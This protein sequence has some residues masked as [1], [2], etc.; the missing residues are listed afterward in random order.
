ML[1]TFSFV[2]DEHPLLSRFSIETYKVSEE[3]NRP[4]QP[5]SNLH[6]IDIGAN[7]VDV[8]RCRF[9]ALTENAQYIPV[10]CPADAPAPMMTPGLADYMRVGISIP[11]G[12][13]SPLSMIPYFGPAWRGKASVEFFWTP[14]S[15]HGETRSRAAPL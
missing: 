3:S 10:L 1:E 8:I 13:G 14:G 2:E 7:S 5:I 15:P 6:E 4:P 11:D 12:R 9:N